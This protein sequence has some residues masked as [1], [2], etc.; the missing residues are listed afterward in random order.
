ME[1]EL[2]SRGLREINMGFIKSWIM[3]SSPP[4]ARRFINV[5]GF[6]F[7]LGPALER[8]TIRK[9]LIP[10][11]IWTFEQEQGLAGTTVS[12]NVRMTA[13]KTSRRSLWI[14]API[15]PTEECVQLLRELELPVEAIVN[16]TYAYEHRVFVPSFSR[17]F[18]SAK[19][20]SVRG[21]SFP[22]PLPDSLLGIDVEAYL[23]ETERLPWLDDFDCELLPVCFVGLAPYTEAAFF[24]RRTKTLITTDLFIKVSETPPEV[25]P[26]AKLEALGSPD[27]VLASLVRG[28][29]TSSPKNIPS[30]V[31]GWMRMTTLALFLGPSSLL[32]PRSA[33]GSI[34]GR[35]TVSPVLRVLVFGKIRSSVQEWT[36]KIM[37]W[38]FDKII[39]AHFDAPVRAG[40]DDMRNALT[41][42]LQG[43][44]D[45]VVEADLK[46]LRGIN[47]VLRSL[48]IVNEEEEYV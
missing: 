41:C 39:P 35:L 12:T 29:A 47:H 43:R 44:A 14:H 26:E 25:I 2:S 16:P 33:F 23:D 8:K 3:S 7:P 46:N 30:N 21:W 9:E 45:G 34:S 5:T 28:S 38:P 40:P 15:A 4:G 20:Y 19:V 24:H 11:S 36:E 1:S 13:V 42:V 48:G 17:R 6:P 18:P 27:S 31:L 32:D 10:G 37:N 22:L